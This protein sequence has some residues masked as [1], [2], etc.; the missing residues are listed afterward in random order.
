MVVAVMLYKKI[1]AENNTEQMVTVVS[2]QLGQPGTATEEIM[3][4]L[5]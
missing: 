1:Y 3:T 5:E 4:V 2:S